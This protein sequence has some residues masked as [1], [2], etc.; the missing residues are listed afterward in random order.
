MKKHNQIL[1]YVLSSLIGILFV[2]SYTLYSRLNNLNKTLDQLYITNSEKDLRQINSLI[3]ESHF[4]DDLVLSSFNI[5]TTIIIAFFTVLIALGAVFS[6]KRVDDEMN[7]NK[8]EIKRVMQNSKEYHN[9]LKEQIEE[10]KSLKNTLSQQIATT[11]TIKNELINSQEEYYL[12]KIQEKQGRIILLTHKTREEEHLQSNVLYELIYTI[13]NIIDHIENWGKINQ[14]LN[15]SQNQN[16]FN[17]LK[18]EFKLI[19]SEFKVV[20]NFL[21]HTQIQLL[22][23][24][25]PNTEQLPAHY[26]KYFD[27][28][29]S[30]L[31]KDN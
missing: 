20:K 8:L 13:T 21:T 15:I 28:I 7:K 9:K 29:K 23:K 18:Y 6:F 22:K 12:T 27:N 17:T 16:Y 31:T 24:T 4:K 2:I 19:E 14:R 10:N 1:I 30:I 11:E 25:Y 5:S 3:F 26:K